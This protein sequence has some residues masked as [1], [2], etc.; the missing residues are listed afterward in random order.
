MATGTGN[1]DGE[2][3]TREAVDGSRVVAAARTVASW[4]RQSSLYR[5]VNGVTETSRRN[6]IRDVVG[7]SRL[8]SSVGGSRLVGAGRVVT[9]AA[10]S[11]ASKVGELTRQSFL[12]RW[13][14]EEPEPD[15]IVIDLRETLTVGPVIR[16]LDRSMAWLAPKW[17][18]SGL[19]RL[20]EQVSARVAERPVRAF[21]IVLTAAVTA[22]L[23]TRVGGGF[24]TG[25]GLL[26]LSL[27]GV[28]VLA[29][30]SDRS[31]DEIRE[32]RGSQLLVAIL[33]P[34]PPPDEE[35][36]RSKGEKPGDGTD[37]SERR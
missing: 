7:G 9:S 21:G 37:R 33:E 15:V 5:L 14:T 1:S 4:A 3:L 26:L 23:A 28:G 27:L 12:Y 20:S 10:A 31:L 8:I 11:V 2:G 35:F 13:L 17:R 30:R 34:P 25:S 36:E 32:T 6:A 16:I 22:R 24:S 19:K 29:L 18:D